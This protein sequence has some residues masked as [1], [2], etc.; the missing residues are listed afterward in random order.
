MRKFH[1]STSDLSRDAEGM[2]E[3]WRGPEETSKT[4]VERGLVG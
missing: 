3:S 1:M 2:G 4:Y